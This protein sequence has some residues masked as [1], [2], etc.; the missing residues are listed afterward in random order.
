MKHPKKPYRKLLTPLTIEAGDG[1][2]V[3][4]EADGAMLC[5]V[6]SWASVN[7]DPT[8][9][10]SVP[11]EEAMFRALEIVAAVNSR[12]KLVE[13]LKK[14]AGCQHPSACGTCAFIAKYAL[15]EGGGQ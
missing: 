4:C 12:G 3:I 13:A 6:P 8:L 1:V 2:H 11:I 7:V 14:V 10:R 9:S 15:S 5:T